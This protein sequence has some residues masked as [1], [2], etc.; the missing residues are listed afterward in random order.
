VEEAT[1]SLLINYADSLIQVGHLKD[2]ST[3]AEQASVKAKV[4]NDE[5]T[6][7]FSL[8][9]RAKIYRAQQ[10]FSS[11]SSMLNELEPL[12]RRSLPPDHYALASISSE[13]SLIAEGRGDLQTALK[14]ATDA[15]SLDEAAI[16]HGGQ[17]AFKLWS[18]YLERAD[19]EISSGLSERAASDA[20]TALE[21]A[22]NMTNPGTF[23]TSIGQCFLTLARALEAEGKHD[24]ARA[25]ALNAV[26]HFQHLLGPAH[27]QTLAAR[28]LAGLLE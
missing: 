18:L 27:P 26:E 9:E 4:A 6:F 7:G 25:S 15:I 23:N 20:A 13:R 5:V 2:A 1:A 17:G 19:I 11:A 21:M 28:Q 24:Q 8:M 3:Y 16:K 22:K 14:L 10:D 12:L